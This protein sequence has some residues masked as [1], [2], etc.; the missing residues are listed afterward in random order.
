VSPADDGSVVA[1]VVCPDLLQR[2]PRVTDGHRDRGWVHPVAVVLALCAAAV[3]AGTPGYRHSTGGLV[4][5]PSRAG[6][7][8]SLARADARSK[9]VAHHDERAPR[10]SGKVT[11]A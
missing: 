10:G 8:P 6:A 2:S 5:R 9:E 1:V 3:V 7:H 4:N 11:A